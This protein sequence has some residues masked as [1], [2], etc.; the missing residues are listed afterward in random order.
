MK[1]KNQLRMFILGFITCAGITLLMGA[2]NIS[3]RPAGI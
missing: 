1:K 2:A 3:P